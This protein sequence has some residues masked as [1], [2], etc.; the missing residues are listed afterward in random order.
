MKNFEQWLE[1]HFIGL[2][3]MDGMPIT[4]DNCEDLFET[5]LQKLDI[6]ELIDFGDLYADEKVEE[7]KKLNNK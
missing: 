4:K 2:L 1:D 6:Q 7:F 3:E 5:W